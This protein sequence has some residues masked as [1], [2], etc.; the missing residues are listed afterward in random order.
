MMLS[1]HFSLTE[2]IH[3]DTAI[4]R[5]IQNIPG[6]DEIASL[7]LLC[8]KLLEPV[9]ER[10]G[11]PIRITSGYRC[12]ELNTL[13]RGSATSQHMKG[14]AADFVVEGM[15]PA[16]VFWEII[17][18]SRTEFDQ[19]INEFGAW[20]HVSYRRTGRHEALMA[21]KDSDGNTEYRHVTPFQRTIMGAGGVA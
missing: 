17:N 9:R 10:I 15:A 20:V 21:F 11:K 5:G 6:P 12:E 8:N 14:E 13:I 4:R 1:K 7:V 18:D 16:D 2:F 19:A 3:S